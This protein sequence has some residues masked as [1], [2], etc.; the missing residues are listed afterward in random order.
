MGEDIANEPV[1]RT[2]LGGFWDLPAWQKAAIGAFLVVT[3]P[4]TGLVLFV[5]AVSMFPFFLF[6]RWEGS[7]DQSLTHE[8]EMGVRRIRTHTEEAY[9]R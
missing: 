3:A 4:F 1:W 5:T 9:S 7:G 6:G 2:F 8:V